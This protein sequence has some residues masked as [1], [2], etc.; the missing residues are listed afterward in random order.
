VTNA[1]AQTIK[2][3]KSLAL[4]VGA[5]ASTPSIA[6]DRK[7][8]CK[9]DPPQDVRDFEPETRISTINLFN[10]GPGKWEFDLSLDKRNATIHWP[11]SPMQLDGRG[12]L[13]QI[14]PTSFA[15]FL[16]SPGPCLFTD[17]NCGSMVI[18]S[19]QSDKS[20]RLLLE[21]L[22]VIKLEESGAQPYKIFINGACKPV[23]VPK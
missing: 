6:K 7:F 10:T 2:S 19:E 20:L 3:L 18:F 5:L 9:L 11:S 1:N 4:L 21:P 14:G 15:T 22:A 16:A 12:P 13:I 17:G 23:D 8:D